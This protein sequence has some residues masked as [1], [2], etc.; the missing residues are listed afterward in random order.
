MSAW[1][2][3]SLAAGAGALMRR[4]NGTTPTRPT[5][6]PP[7]HV[8]ASSTVSA[9]DAEWAYGY[10]PITWVGIGLAI[11]ANLLIAVFA[12]P[13]TCTP[14]RLAPPPDAHGLCSRTTHAAVLA[15]PR[16]GRL[17]RVY[18]AQIS[19]NIQKFAHNQNAARGAN[20][21]PYHKIPIWWA[22]MALNAFGEVGNLVAY[23]YAEATVV[24]PIGLL[25]VVRCVCTRTRA[26]THARAHNIGVGS[27][28][29]R[30]RSPCVLHNTCHVH[31]C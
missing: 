28:V 13:R 19:L 25:C 9:D 23:G 17:T 21:L 16:R 24:T 8:G 3:S 27:K 11:F 18:P 10:D 22:G 1:L 29:F 7:Q 5:Q 6:P 2:S 30:S 31:A 4:A 15:H 12:A 14:L 26:R 20:R